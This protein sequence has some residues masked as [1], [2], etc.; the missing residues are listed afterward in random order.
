L[1]ANLLPRIPALYAALANTIQTD[2]DIV[3]AVRLTRFALGLDKSNVH[4][5]VLGPPKLLTPGW[6]QGMSIFV[7]DWPA[8]ADGVQHVFDRPTFDDEVANA[9]H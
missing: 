5:F 4:G 2:I 9:C 6:R 8:I 1:Q 3:T 7:A